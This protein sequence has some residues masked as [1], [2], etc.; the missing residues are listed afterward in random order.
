MLLPHH[1]TSPTSTSTTSASDPSREPLL[2][3]SERAALPGLDPLP[4]SPTGALR[5]RPSSHP[6]LSGNYAPVTQELPLTACRLAPGFSARSIPREL[7]GGQY[8]RNG[9]NPAPGYMDSERAAHWFDGDGMLAGVLFKRTG[10]GKAR[11]T[12][13]DVVGDEEEEEDKE[14]IEPL[15]V[16]R[17]IQTDV[18]SLTPESIRKPLIP[19][20]ATLVSPSVSYFSL[21]LAVLRTFLWYAMTWLPGLGL[22]DDDGGSGNGEKAKRLSVANA[23][24]WWHDGKVLAGCESGPPMW[25]QLPKFETVGWYTGQDRAATPPSTA[26]AAVPTKKQTTKKGWAHGWNPLLKHFMEY[27]TAH[28][29]DTARFPALRQRG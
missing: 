14:E 29:S 7:A 26:A 13:G 4:S 21:L 15:F 5:T 2:T 18:K 6:Y 19:S 11:R 24:V 17:F 8:V 3:L 20:I 10:K 27:T 16:N 1:A 23:T 25:V 22:L 9:G 12:D 28:V